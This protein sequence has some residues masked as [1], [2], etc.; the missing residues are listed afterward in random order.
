M[1]YY[2]FYDSDEDIEFVVN[3]DS[4]LEAEYTAK[5]YFNYPKFQ[6][7]IDEEEALDGDYDIF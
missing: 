1:K 5:R 2:L 6:E 4:V 7:E 3:A